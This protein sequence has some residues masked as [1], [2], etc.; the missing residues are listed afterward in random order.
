MAKIALPAFV[1]S[2]WW[3]H[4]V[5]GFSRE[6]RTPFTKSIWMIDT[7]G[8]KYQFAAYKCETKEDVP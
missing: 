6:V 4:C 3:L 7:T 2:E 5:M 1:A 8:T